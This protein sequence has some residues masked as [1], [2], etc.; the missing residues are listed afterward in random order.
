MITTPDLLSQLARIDEGRSDLI[1]RAKVE[2]DSAAFLAGLPD[3]GLEVIPSKDGPLSYVVDGGEPADKSK[4]TETFDFH[5][6]GLYR[7]NLPRYVLLYC[8]DAGS[9]T[10][11]TKLSDGKLALQLIRKLPE[12]PR[13]DKLSAV[14]VARDGQRYPRSIVQQH[15]ATGEDVLAFGSRAYF[16][17]DLTGYPAIEL[18]TL[19]EAAR[20]GVTLFDAIDRCTC[21]E[22]IWSAHELLMFDNLRFVHKREARQRDTDRRLLRVWL[23]PAK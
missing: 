21:Y 1:F 6:D 14:Y 23:A 16:E 13:L 20:A 8:I 15:P 17:P 22:M 9:A 2:F 5:T 10:V 11:T 7:T 19:R 4:S 12:P 18:P 3:V